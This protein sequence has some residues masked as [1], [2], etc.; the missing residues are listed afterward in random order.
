[1]VRTGR[2]RSP[3]AALVFPILC[4]VGGA[5]L[6]THSHASLNIKSEYLIEVTHAP[7]GVLAML[8][9]WGRWLELRLP[10]GERALPGQVW[11]VCLALVGVMLLLYHEL[12]GRRWGP[13]CFVAALGRRFDVQEYASPAALGR[14]LA[15]GP[16]STP[17]DL[18]LRKSNSFE[19]EARQ[20]ARFGDRQQDRV[21]AALG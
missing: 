12:A 17:C 2:I 9:G 3:R 6:L 4:S 1:M 19:Q 10:P 11:S 16:F 20:V 21:V 14:R 5:L 18:P 13:I 15:S 7:L 8:V